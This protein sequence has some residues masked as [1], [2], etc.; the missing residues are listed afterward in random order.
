MGWQPIETAPQE[1]N[2]QI[3]I[4]WPRYA[5]SLDEESCPVISIGHWK[6]NPRIEAAIH[7][8]EGEAVE[9]YGL[10][11]CYFADNDELDDY[12]LAM[13]AHAPTH[14]M[15]LPAPPK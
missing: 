14:W 2:T 1:F 15:P 7:S 6:D 13:A 8:R 3:L 9:R 12:G 5:Y 10:S 4:F 11:R